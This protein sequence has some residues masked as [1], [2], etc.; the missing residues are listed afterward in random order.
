[1]IF[2]NSNTILQIKIINKIILIFYFKTHV[3]IDYVYN[4]FFK[5]TIT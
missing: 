1:M 5:I 4:F 2:S 3:I